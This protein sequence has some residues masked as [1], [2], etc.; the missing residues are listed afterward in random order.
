MENKFDNSE[1]VYSNSAIDNDNSGK[2]VERND[3]KLPITRERSVET[4]A[5]IVE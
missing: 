5:I 2:H 3:M 1:A 4:L